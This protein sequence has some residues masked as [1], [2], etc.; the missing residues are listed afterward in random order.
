MRLRACV[1]AAVA[2]A[3]SPSRLQAESL[4]APATLRGRVLDGNGLP[5]AGYHI[6]LL[7]LRYLSV[8]ETDTDR[9]GR[10]EFE[11]V[12]PTAYALLAKPEQPI[13]WA[14]TYYPGV[15][16]RQQA[17][18][19]VIP[20][21]AELEGYEFRLATSPS[22][23]VRGTVVDEMG[24]PMP[25]ARVSIKAEGAPGNEAIA[26]A[27]AD[28]RFEFPA[29][30]PG[31]WRCT[32]ETGGAADDSGIPAAV[33][34]GGERTY[35]G[36]AVVEVGNRDVDGVE[37]RLTPPF[38]VGL[39]V[40]REESENSLVAARSES[41]FLNAMDGVDEMVGTTSTDTGGERRFER[42]FPGRY[43]ISVGDTEAGY[44]LAAVTLGDRD[45]LGQEFELTAGSPDIRAVF[46]SRPGGANGTVDGS[47][48]A[49]VV[50]LPQAESLRGVDAIPKTQC[51]TD[52]RFEL[53][54]LRPDEYYAWAFERVDVEALRDVAFVRT[55]IPY[56]TAV[57]VTRGAAASVRLAVT[58]WPE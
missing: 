13:P 17:S 51:Q 31:W 12:R 54:G 36:F 25:H 38:A 19:I 34:S 10:F 41:I 50:L 24:T 30:V 43:K 18:P 3:F 42:V 5:V 23:H 35:R 9:E 33:L 11:D 27:G 32:A 37:I 44:Y 55:L 39:S 8:Y 15:L 20:S 58:P 46:R 45:V 1:F 26:D 2:L 52:G 49:M 40:W 48:Q 22:F 14:T 29:V 47:E 57:R 4:S 56:A 28:G 16:D 21:G 6:R 53:A 7:C